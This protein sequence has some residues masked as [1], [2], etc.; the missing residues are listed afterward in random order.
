[1]K[2]KF[3]SMYVSR[4][5]LQIPGTVRF[6]YEERESLVLE[7]MVEVTKSYLGIHCRQLREEQG[8]SEIEDM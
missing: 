3:S 8:G 1:M 7:Y 2:G 4:V 5:F 6:H